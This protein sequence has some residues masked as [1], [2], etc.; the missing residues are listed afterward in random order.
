MNDRAVGIFDSGFGGLTGLAAFRELMPRENIIY[1]GDTKN[2]PYGSKSKEQLQKLA[3]DNIDFLKSKGVKSII[4]ACGTVSS[5]CGDLLKEADI[6]I[7]NVLDATLQTVDKMEGSIALIATEATVRTNAFRLPGREIRAIA[8]PDFVTL[9]ESGHTSPEDS[10]LQAAIEKYLSPLK[11][12]DILILGCTHYPI[13]EEAIANYMGKNTKIVSA[14]RCAAEAMAKYLKKYDLTGG[15]GLTEVYT[16]GNTE[17]FDAIA[18]RI[19]DVK[20]CNY[21]C[22]RNP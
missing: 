3:Y 9:I 16:S 17:S 20:R 6:Y 22:A 10:S 19:L 21:R 15:E 7:E 4:A 14:S 12:T 5:N 2:I 1:F 11:G 18:K 13:I 8:C